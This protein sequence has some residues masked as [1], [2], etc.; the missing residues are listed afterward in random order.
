ME[1]QIGRCTAPCV[2]EIS[3]TEYRKDIEA[4]KTIL[5]G[6]FKH[7]EKKMK[8][9]MVQAADLEKF[10]QAAAIRDSSWYSNK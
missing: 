6:N 3:K 10:E 1:Y 2:G 7:L 5:K 9:E 8:E 4:T